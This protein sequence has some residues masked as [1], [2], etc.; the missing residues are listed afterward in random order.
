MGII[1]LK[2]IE[3]ETSTVEG[4]EKSAVTEE[5]IPVE[6]VAAEENDLPKDALF[7]NKEKKTAYQNVFRFNDGTTRQIVSGAPKN[8]MD[9]KTNQHKKI[10]TCLCKNT[11]GDLECQTNIFETKFYA[12]AE[13]GKIYSIKRNNCDVTLIAKDAEKSDVIIEQLGAETNNKAIRELAGQLA[14]NTAM[15][16]KSRYLDFRRL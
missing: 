5:I 16:V 11:E 4:L 6:N 15:L 10:K 2:K 9:K 13:N 14:P 3:E 7:E 1:K 8:Y 12:K